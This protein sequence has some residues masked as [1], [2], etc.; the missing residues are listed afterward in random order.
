MHCPPC[1]CNTALLVETQGG[2]LFCFLGDAQI[3]DSSSNNDA[4]LLV[5]ISATTAQDCLRILRVAK[6]IDPDSKE[7]MLRCHKSKDS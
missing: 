7:N 3:A 5:V 1:T 4:V 2:F 6:D